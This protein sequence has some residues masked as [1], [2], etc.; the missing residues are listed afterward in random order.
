MYSVFAQDLPP[1]NSKYASGT[2]LCGDARDCDATY[3]A[4]SLGTT[5]TQKYVNK[6]CKDGSAN[7]LCDNVTNECTASYKC[8]RDDI[9]MDCVPDTDNPVLDPQG[10]T[11]ISTE[12]T[13]ETI[14]CSN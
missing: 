2:A 7:E 12:E 4:C 13:P 3:P 14:S 10:E 5:V 6:E 1:C 11:V 8:K 9:N